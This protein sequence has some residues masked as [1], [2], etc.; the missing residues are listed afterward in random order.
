MARPWLTIFFTLVGLGGLLGYQLY[1]DYSDISSQEQQRLVSLA[2]AFNANMGEQLRASSAMLGVLTHTAPTLLSEPE[3][4]A[5]LNTRMS[6]LS[7]SVT[8][9]RTI[10]LVNANGIVVSSNRSELVGLGFSGSERYT[11]ISEGPDPAK[12][13][14]SAPFTTPL[15]AYTISLGRAIVNTQGEFDGYLLA[16]LAP[17]YF[18]VLMKSLLYAPDMR[19]SVTHGD[20][21]V[22][23]STQSTP[24]I[25]GLDLSSNPQSLF[26]HHK[27]SGGPASFVIDRIASTN[28]LRYVA[29]HSVWPAS[30]VA[31]KELV[32][33]V[34]RDASAVLGPWKTSAINTAGLYLGIVLTVCLGYL[35]YSRR[36]AAYQ[37]LVLQEEETNKQADA[38]ARSE[39]FIRTITDAMPGL[40]AYFDRSLRCCFANQAYL[41]W[42]QMTSE[43]MSGIT[44]LELLG[45]S[46]FA[47]NKPYIDGVL[48]G[49]SQQ[50]ERFLTKRDGSVGHV[51]A[52]YIPDFDESGD[53][54]GFNL[55]VTD[56]KA[57]RMA[58]A[59]LKVAE[60]VFENTA[61][62][63]MVA[64]EN[65]V[66]LSVN[67]A[68]TEITGYPAHEA[69]GQTPRLLRSNHHAPEFHAAVWQQITEQGEWKGEIWNR[70]KN[71]E[72]FPMRQ[73]IRRVAEK[74]S[75]LRR[76]ISVFHD[77]TDVWR[78]NERTQ[79]LAFHD[80]LTDLPNRTLLLERLERQIVMSERQPR[81]LAVLF[82]DLDGFKRVNDTLG[83]AIGDELL[84]AVANKL[85][86]LVRQTDTVARL[87]GDE[88]VVLLDSPQNQEEVENIAD[89]IIASINEPVEL[90]GAVAKVGTSIGI[91][92]YPEHGRSSSDLLKNADDAMYRAKHEGKNTY[93]LASG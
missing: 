86:G 16:I 30:I 33:A 42:Y 28:D 80:A 46:L 18:G 72:I 12:L 14:I 39:R 20:G 2:S 66:I 70:R 54:I 6:L 58:E 1:D 92:M 4:V 50:F 89:R 52:N 73:T 77:I 56:I 11:T 64:D 57:L 62:G 44:L 59:D 5:R 34:S 74:G 79:H 3:G 32:V 68:F 75:G 67:D 85:Q 29:F 63:I 8:G 84:K 55:L 35:A 45:E 93:R 78:K 69:V 76:Y 37:R 48:A 60:T 38:I 40:V 81:C 21:K 17:D 23:Y 91:A 24:D 88:F 90:S 10:I 7:E 15:G 65:G 25:R 41:D 13:Y 51:L 83:H 71:G 27:A 53:V 49:E 61:D 26:N 22:I 47:K 31:D 19:L 43:A 36:H 82:L 9:I 87:G